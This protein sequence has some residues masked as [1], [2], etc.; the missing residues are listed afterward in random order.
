M[1]TKHT[2]GPWTVG[3]FINNDFEPMYIEVRSGVKFI[4]KSTYGSADNIE[5]EANAKLIAAAPIMLER[6][7]GLNTNLQS[8]ID[9]NPPEDKYVIDVLEAIIRNNERIIRKVEIGQ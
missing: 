7:K 5:R 3:K 2:P 8:W 9:E 4:A 6:L 1:K